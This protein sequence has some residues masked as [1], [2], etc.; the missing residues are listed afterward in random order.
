MMINFK[1]SALI[2]LSLCFFT[3]GC[4]TYN[5]LALTHDG[6]ISEDYGHRTKGTKVE[7][8]TIEAKAKINIERS[9]DDLALANVQ[10]KSYNRVVL[11]TGQVSSQDAFNTVTSVVKNIRHVRRLHNKLSLENKTS[12][13][14]KDFYLAT[15]INSRL[16]FAEGIDSDRVEIVVENA[17]VY[18][19]GLVTQD[20]SERIVKSV[21][22]VSGLNKII[23]VFEYINA[24]LS[25]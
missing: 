5:R 17:E 22:Q 15:K 25:Q 4:T 19:M 9:S 7:D 16:Y 2:C 3:N 14:S 10:V 18:L 8:T 13:D 1:R 24:D 12:S 21:Q 11:I 6:L 20:E 23:K